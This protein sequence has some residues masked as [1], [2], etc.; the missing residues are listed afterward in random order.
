MTFCQIRATRKI[1]TSKRGFFCGKQR[2][3]ERAE[4]LRQARMNQR[5]KLE[6]NLN[7]KNNFQVID[8]KGQLLGMATMQCQP[9]II[10]AGG[11]NTVVLNRPI[12][13]DLN[14]QTPRLIPTTTRA[15]I[16]GKENTFRFAQ[17]GSG[18]QVKIAIRNRL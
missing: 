8:S 13:S 7:F 6:T 3:I 2:E 18:G 14:A 10:P 17:M 1:D 4:A 15:V 11:E 9:N 16:Q 5:F 12:T